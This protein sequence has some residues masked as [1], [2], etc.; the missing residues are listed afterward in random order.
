M[1]P[2]LVTWADAH[3]VEGWLDPANL[4]NG[5]CIVRSV[6]WLIADAKAGHVTLALSEDENGLV[7]EVFHIGV[8]MVLDMIA[9]DGSG[10]RL[11]AEP[12]P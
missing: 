4:D 5:P 3:A 1:T 8:A 7:R 9:L 10:A 2:V 11:T 12:Q 6:G